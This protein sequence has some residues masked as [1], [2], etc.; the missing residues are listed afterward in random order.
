MPLWIL[1]AL[2]MLSEALLH[3]FP[4]KLLLRGRELPRV[5]AYTLGVI[6]LMVPF[7]AWLLYNSD[8]VIVQALWIAVGS[9]GLIVFALYGFDRYLE[10]EMRNIEATERENQH[11]RSTDVKS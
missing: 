4:Y 8:I 2:V 3:Y 1:I 5:A 10:L 7:T 11:R 9:G 6:G